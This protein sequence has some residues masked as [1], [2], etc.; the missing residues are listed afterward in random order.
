MKIY[1]KTFEYIVKTIPLSILEFIRGSL[2]GKL[3]H[4]HPFIGR[5]YHKVYSFLRN[6]YVDKE[7]GR[8][9]LDKGDVL[10]LS[11]GDDFEK[12]EVEFF[13]KWIDPNKVV[14]DV[15][16]HIGFY[17]LLANFHGCRVYSFE[18]EVSTFDLLWKNV[19]E[20]PSI[21]VSRLAVSDKNEVKEFNVYPSGQSSFKHRPEQQDLGKI[22]V[23]CVRLDDV[24]NEP[25]GF[26]KVD[27]EYWDY[28]VLLGAEKI[29]GKYRPVIM[30]EFCNDNRIV[31]FLESKNYSVKV[32]SENTVGNAV[33]AVPKNKKLLKT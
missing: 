6:P 28:N 3:T 5:T 14:V 7:F 22:M 32:G 24:I 2:S 20:F 8:I 29:I 31:D 16:A 15:G 33:Y 27:T 25:V 21:V 12:E 4:S 19:K 10:G 9:Y 13:K 18:P 26:I 11:K 1:K 17:S 23:P 30:T